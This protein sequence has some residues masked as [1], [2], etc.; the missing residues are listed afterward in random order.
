MSCLVA[1]LRLLPHLIHNPFPSLSLKVLYRVGGQHQEYGKYYKVYALNMPRSK[2]T[3]K[4][5]KSSQPKPN[6][7]VSP[8]QT[9][10]LPIKEISELLDSLFLNACVELARQILSSAPTLPSGPASLRAV[11]KIVVL[12]VAEYGSTA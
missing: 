9:K 7:L 11:L 3:V 1:V 4:T 2:K 5:S 6:D 12:F 8:L 10:H